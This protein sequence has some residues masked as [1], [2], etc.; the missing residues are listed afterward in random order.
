LDL[1]RKARAE[2]RATGELLQLYAL[3]GFLDRLAASSFRSRLV[4]KSGA[5][6]AAYDV[7]RAT[8]DLDFQAL[9]L[10]N[11]LQKLLAV[12]QEIAAVARPDG[13]TF[14]VQRATARAIREGDAYQG[15]RVSLPCR[16][17]SARVGFGV[18]LSVGDPIWPGPEPVSVSRLLGESIVLSGYPL[19]MV[20]A[21]KIV[22]AVQR[23]TA[24]TRWRD[25]AD[26]VLLSGR[27]SVSGDGL[28][29]AV[30]EVA[31]YRMATLAPLATALAGYAETG[32]RRWALW[33]RSVRL[34]ASL[35]ASFG[36]VLKAVVQFADPVLQ[37]KVAGKTW[38][39]AKRAWR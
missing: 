6:L 18:D 34:E 35:P 10:P 1:Q 29:R 16:L 19:A 37:D 38:S 20:H 31:D 15:V 33:C 13:L 23:G 5:L 8:R 30:V 4:L 32:Q 2:G 9:K 36:E 28:R 14:D 22:T 11:A 12:V 24:S 26:L 17:A 39:A 27:H 21:E 7:R 3:E 25:F